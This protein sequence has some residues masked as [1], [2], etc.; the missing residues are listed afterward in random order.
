MIL[1]V[2]SSTVLELLVREAILSNRTHG[3]RKPTWFATQI[4]SYRILRTF[5]GSEGEPIHC[6]D[7]PQEEG[8]GKEKHW[9]VCWQDFCTPLRTPL[10]FIAP[11]SFSLF[12]NLM[13]PTEDPRH[14]E[15]IRSKQ[16]R[17]KAIR[18]YLGYRDAVENRQRIRMQNEERATIGPTKEEV[19][20]PPPSQ[21]S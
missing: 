20:S 16:T 8:G 2:T 6:S 14:H 1:T 3:D 10:N 21:R 9:I 5:R 15:A 12:K 13:M 11:F 18:H 4:G 17:R 7:Q 19:K